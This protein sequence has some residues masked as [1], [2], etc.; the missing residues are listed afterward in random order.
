VKGAFQVNRAEW[1]QGRVW[2]LVDDVVTTGST[3]DAAAE[4]LR[5]AGATGAVPVALALA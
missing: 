3:L 2:V 1:V 5:E 4:E